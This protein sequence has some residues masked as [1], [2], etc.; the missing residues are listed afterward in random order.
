MR[1]M[2]FSAACSALP[3]GILHIVP[4][5]PRKIM[6]R[7]AAQLYIAMMAN[8]EAVMN[9]AIRQF[10]GDPMRIFHMSFIGDGIPYS[11][12]SVATRANVS[13]PKPAGIGTTRFI[14]LFP[15][16]SCKW[17]FRAQHN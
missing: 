17:F 2:A 3:C 8:K 11:K 14:D 13:C 7:I 10:I 4:C 16:A 9:K 15:E 6:S 5:G 12:A 1:A